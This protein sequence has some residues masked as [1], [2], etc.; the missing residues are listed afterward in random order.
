MQASN[1]NYP[2]VQFGSIKEALDFFPV[3]AV[4]GARQVGK[5][6]LCRAIAEQHGM[7]QITLDQVDTLEEARRDPAGLIARAGDRGLFI[8]E[9]Q[10]A[11]ALFLAIKAEVDRNQKPGRFL[12]SGSNQPKVARH[13]GDSLQGRALYR[14]LR[15]LVLSE[16]RMS[17]RHRGWDFLFGDS[18]EKILQELATRADESG[19]LDWQEAIVFGGFPRA[20]AAPP[21]QRTMLLDSYVHTFAN[22]D[23]REIL[24]VESTERFESLVR[25]VATRIGRPL[26]TAGMANELGIGVKTAASWLDAM[27][28]S[29]VIEKIP[30][31]HKNP[32]QRVIKAPKL[33]LVDAALALAAARETAPTGF[34]FENL[35]ATD[36]LVWREDG[37]GRALYHWQLGAGQEVDFVLERN[38]ELVPVEVKVG[39]SISTGDTKHLKK[40]LEL[41]PNAKRGLLLSSDPQLRVFSSRIV[42]A[43]WWAVL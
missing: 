41:H 6:T 9:A 19:P 1:Q 8:D 22:R 32:S 11:P 40:F 34:H 29:Y 15:P 31:F 3:V 28:R 10:R 26:N 17:E 7:P 36:L 30:A 25:L 35:I 13:V 38:A 4:M 21:A 20:V 18:Q 14:T 43:P 2:R 12:L 42:A 39:A 33:F 16:L 37:Y 24:G 27:A 5:S 23:I